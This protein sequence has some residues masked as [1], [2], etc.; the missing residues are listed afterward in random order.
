MNQGLQKTD[1]AYMKRVCTY[2]YIRQKTQQVKPN[3][4]LASQK[5]I[6]TEAEAVLLKWGALAWTKSEGGV[7]A[8]LEPCQ[9]W[10][11]R[12]CI[13]HVDEPKRV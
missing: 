10:N 13:C 12:C 3:E 5:V 2:I 11:L 4:R 7:V 8:S 9:M 1:K 6:I